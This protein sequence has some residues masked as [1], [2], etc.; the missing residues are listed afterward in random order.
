[1]GSNKNIH[2][3]VSLRKRIFYAFL[4][5]LCP[6]LILLIFLIEL[7]LVPAI[8]HYAREELVNSTEIFTQTVRSS[9]TI[10]VRSYLHAI[11]DN[12]R[13]IAREILSK[14]DREE[15]RD[16]AIRRIKQIFLSQQVGS[17]G[18]IYCL[19]SAGNIPIHPKA[20]VEH[21]NQ[22]N[23][24]FIRTQM[25][26]KEGY[27]E[28]GWKNPGEEAERG[29]ALYMVYLKSLDWIISASSYRSEFNELVHPEDVKDVISSAKFGKSGYAYMLDLNGDILIHPKVS[30]LNIFA[31]NYFPTDFA[32][33]IVR[34][35]NGILEYTWKNPNE[36]KPHKKI[37][38]YK[39]VP[40]FDWII[41]SSAYL[42]EINQPVW[43]ARGIAY[44]SIAL[45]LL[46]GGITAYLLSRYL[47]NPIDKMIRQLDYNS[48]THSLSPVPIKTRDELGRLGSEINS[49]GV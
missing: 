28:Y 35:R 10:A 5:A 33:T 42:S 37:V 17:S 27:I 26:K 41:C 22:S 46:S 2:K 31:E 1:M 20:G 32:K 23:F 15:N 18:Y 49:F 30:K 16:E 48:S 13:Q 24:A 45:L 36:K 47:T 19:D 25:R 34:N 39:S 40:G 11:A 3:I 38:V 12:N 8:E 9:A 29:K 7:I 43:M 14:I 44:T 4:T 6:V 21:T